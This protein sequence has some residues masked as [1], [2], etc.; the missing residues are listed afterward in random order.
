LHCTEDTL[1]KTPHD[2]WILVK[3]IRE[4]QKLLGITASKPV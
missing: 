4:G 2:D 1:L 3:N